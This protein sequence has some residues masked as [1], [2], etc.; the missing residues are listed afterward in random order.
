MCTTQMRSRKACFV[1][2]GAAHLLCRL[3]VAMLLLSTLYPVA[4]ECWKTASAISAVVVCGVHGCGGRATGITRHR[5]QAS[6][7]QL[8]MVSSE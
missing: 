3:L 1:A 4:G 2:S 5:G 6:A 7:V 8:R